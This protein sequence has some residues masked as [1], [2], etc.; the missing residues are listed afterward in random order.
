MALRRVQR[1]G[2][3]AEDAAVFQGL[4]REITLQYDDW[5]IRLH[6]GVTP[7][8][9][10]RILNKTQNDVLYQPKSAE[11]SELAQLDVAP[12]GASLLELVSLDDAKTLL[13]IPV[14]PE[15][16]EF[17]ADLLTL[18]DL[19]AAKA[20]LEIP[21]A[22]PI[23]SVSATA[24]IVASTTTGAVTVSCT[25]STQPQAEA[26]TAEDV[27]MVPLRVEQQI[28]GKAHAHIKAVR[29]VPV[30]GTDGATVTLD[31]SAN[32]HTVTLGG[33]RTLGV[34]TNGGVGQQGVIDVGQDA[35]GSRT[36]AYAWCWGHPGGTAPTLTTAALACDLLS[37]HVRRWAISTMTISIATP[38][39]V[40]WA[41]HGLQTGDWLQLT[42]TGALPTGLTASTTYWV[43]R[44]DADTIRLATS[45]A[46][47][48]AGTAIATSG[49][50]SG[51][52]T[53]TCINIALAPS[54]DFR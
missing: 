23:Q 38:G 12:F 41:S 39:V 40:T 36:L 9:V 52:H 47:A 4:E 30:A 1:V 7:G 17:G 24:P 53:A 19:D 33:N 46:N 11:L 29:G 31:L 21:S 27:L 32:H 44:V 28:V 25:I 26:G 45:K 42:T 51:A 54:K 16:T 35:T 14:L 13:E 37:Y 15:V 3:S 43:I 50:Q 6:D 8:G 5:E 20:L 2:H 49:T 48:A 10:A 22:A 34:P 18:D